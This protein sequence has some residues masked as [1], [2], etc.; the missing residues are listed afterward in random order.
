MSC[1]RP[2]MRRPHALPPLIFSSRPPPAPRVGCS[3]HWCHVGSFVLRALFLT[4]PSCACIC[5]SIQLTWQATSRSK[6]ERLSLPSVALVAGE[7]Q[8]PVIWPSN[9][10]IT[11]VPRISA[12]FRCTPSVR[13]SRP[14]VDPRPG[15]VAPGCS[16][17]CARQ[18]CRGDGSVGARLRR[19]KRCRRPSIDGSISVH[20]PFCS[21]RLALWE[22]LEI[23]VRRLLTQ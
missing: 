18:R 3:G 4:W 14:H 11:T 23:R 6:P 5:A 17:P 12:W 9:G 22:A 15:G 8:S 21:S 20:M 10:A 13:L 19:R 7:G 1:L 16:T 2:P